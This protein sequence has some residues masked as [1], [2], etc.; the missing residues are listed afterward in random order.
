VVQGPTIRELPA[1]PMNN[2]A[3]KSKGDFTGVV[4]NNT[5]AATVWIVKYIGK[6][7]DCRFPNW[8]LGRCCYEREGEGSIVYPEL[9]GPTN[10]A[11]VR[12]YIKK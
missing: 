12:K 6:I 9:K 10:E 8:I 4:K 11:A 5:A 2:V 7:L 3:H 1:D